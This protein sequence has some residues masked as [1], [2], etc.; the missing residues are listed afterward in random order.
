MSPAVWKYLQ[1]DNYPYALYGPLRCDVMQLRFIGPA[2]R[3]SLNVPAVVYGNPWV[4]FNRY[5]DDFGLPGRCKWPKLPS[6][7]WANRPDN[8]VS[9]CAPLPINQL[10]QLH[11]ITGHNEERCHFVVSDTATGYSASVFLIME[12]WTG[13]D[14][15]QWFTFTVYRIVFRSG[16]HRTNAGR[17]EFY[18]KFIASA[19]DQV[20][21]FH[22]Q[23]GNFVNLDVRYKKSGLLYQVLVTYS[24]LQES[25]PSFSPCSRDDKHHG[26]SSIFYCD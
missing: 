11:Q 20:K 10:M 17:Q 6:V 14:S 18:Y 24:L 21:K 26:R 5:G 15:I 25:C 13:E 2:Q 3:H 23:S 19:E 22:H 7:W 8:Q 1:P 4:T 16:M 9:I 12:T